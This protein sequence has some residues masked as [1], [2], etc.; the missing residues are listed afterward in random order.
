MMYTNYKL[1]SIFVLNFL[2]GI[3]KFIKAIIY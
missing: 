1:S 2:V 3:N